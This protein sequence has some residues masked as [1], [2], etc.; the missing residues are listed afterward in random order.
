MARTTDDSALYKPAAEEADY[1]DLVNENTDITARL[2]NQIKVIY[3]ADEIDM[4]GHTVYITTTG[5]IASDAKVSFGASNTYDFDNRNAAYSSAPERAGHYVHDIDLS[6]LTLTPTKVGFGNPIGD[7]SGRVLVA[8]WEQ[9]S[10]STWV[11][12][13][14]CWAAMVSFV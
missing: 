6:G 5:Q 2:S 7:T 4:N 14:S 10:E 8:I 12:V 13:A 3:P 9:N 1:G 11:V